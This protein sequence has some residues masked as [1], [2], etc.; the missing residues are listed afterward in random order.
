MEDR[1]FEIKPIINKNS[2]D[3]DKELLKS[4]IGLVIPVNKFETEM[5]KIMRRKSSCK[6]WWDNKPTKIWDGKEYHDVNY[7][8]C[9]SSHRARS[10]FCLVLDMED[11]FVT[12]KN[13][14]LEAI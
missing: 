9:P 13:G 5:Q 11:G 10:F 14:F 12:V 3:F 8:C 4:M 2:N 1:L 7:R 6:L